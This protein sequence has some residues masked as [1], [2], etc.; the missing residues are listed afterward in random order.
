MAGNIV[1]KC[2]FSTGV[3]WVCDKLLPFTQAQV[4]FVESAVHASAILL[5]TRSN[6]KMRR[7]LWESCNTVCR[8]ISSH[9]ITSR[10]VLSLMKFVDVPEEMLSNCKMLFEWKLGFEGISVFGTTVTHL[11][12]MDVFFS[13]DMKTLVR[14]YFILLMRSHSI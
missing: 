11:S 5:Q 2:L 13:Y 7:K 8:L 12:E 4:V 3:V 10:N 14:V 9:V 6:L 1:T